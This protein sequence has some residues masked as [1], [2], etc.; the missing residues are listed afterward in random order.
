MITVYRN[1]S[2]AS[3]IEYRGPPHSLNDRALAFAFE[4]VRDLADEAYGNH[5]RSST[6][7]THARA[8]DGVEFMAQNGEGPGVPNQNAWAG[9]VDAICEPLR[10]R[11]GFGCAGAAGHPPTCR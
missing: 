3:V 5:V 7:G 1:G 8:S 6:L 11:V 10:G 9:F 4:A 2:L